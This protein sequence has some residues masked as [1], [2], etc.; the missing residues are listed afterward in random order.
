MVAELKTDGDAA[1]DEEALTAIEGT[2]EAEGE[3]ATAAELDVLA[4]AQVKLGKKEKAKETLKAPKESTAKA[5]YVALIELEQE[6]GEAAELDTYVNGEKGQFDVR[7]KVKENRTLVPIRALVE[8]LGAQISFDAGTQT[9]T[10]IKGAQ[11][12][13]LTIGSKVALVNGV[14]VKLD[15]AAEIDG[16]RIRRGAYVEA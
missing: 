1:T 14:E 15:A 10:I 9:V 16:G 4:Q 6:S 8:K 13:K 3:A 5:A 7:P 12:I 11:E 2:V